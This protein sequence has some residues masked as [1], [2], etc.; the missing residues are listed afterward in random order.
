MVS[1]IADT[2]PDPAYQ[3]IEDD[4]SGLVKGHIEDQYPRKLEGGKHTSE[5]MRKM[6]EVSYLNKTHHI[7]KEE[8]NA[9]FTPISRFNKGQTDF[10]YKNIERDIEMMNQT[11]RNEMKDTLGYPREGLLRTNTKQNDRRGVY[12]DF[13]EQR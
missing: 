2:E 4:F 9:K 11:V 6:H 8:M 5:I 7:S 10:T 1:S 12:E 13:V 3:V